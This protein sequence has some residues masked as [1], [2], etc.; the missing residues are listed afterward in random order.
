[1]FRVVSD[2]QFGTRDRLERCCHDGWSRK[3]WYILIRKALD[4]QLAKFFF[5]LSQ[6]RA[7]AS[8]KCNWIFNYFASWYIHHQ[9]CLNQIICSSNMSQLHFQLEWTT[10][11]TKIFIKH[12]LDKYFFVPR[13]NF[14]WYFIKKKFSFQ[15]EFLL[16]KYSSFG[17]SSTKYIAE[18]FFHSSAFQKKRRSR[19]G[20][21][22]N[23]SWRCDKW[24]SDNWPY[25]NGEPAGIVGWVIR[26]GMVEFLHFVRS[27]CKF[28]EFLS[29]TCVCVCVRE[30]EREKERER[31]RYR[32]CKREKDGM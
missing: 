32:I 20:E 15:D 21:W 1:M 12:K 30:R 16:L 23:K 17:K 7:L 3:P 19:V 5:P 2:R 24:S 26:V 9:M 25:D 11:E 28:K 13:Q 27:F 31:E 14:S 4:V 8:E 6:S 22:L 10:L 18:I 29:C